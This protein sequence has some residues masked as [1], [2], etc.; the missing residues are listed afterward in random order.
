MDYLFAVAGGVLLG[1]AIPG[2]PS[3]ARVLRGMAAILGVYFLIW[4]SR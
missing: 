4:A 1:L 2:E 3:L